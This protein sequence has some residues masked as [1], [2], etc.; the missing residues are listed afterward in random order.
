MNSILLYLGHQTAWQ[1]LPFNFSH[2]SMNTHWIRL[3]ES[4][5]GVSA[6]LIVAFVL[7]KKKVFVTV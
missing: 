1:M 5:W 6:W 4:L 7:Y 3:I 2:G